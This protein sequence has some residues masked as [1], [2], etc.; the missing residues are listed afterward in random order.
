[1]KRKTSFGI[2]NFYHVFNRGVEKRK[3]F[4][5][6]KDYQRF[7]LL[8]FFCNGSVP[9]QMK[10][11]L[12]QG[13]SQGPSLGKF[14]RGKQLVDI[15][16]YCLMPNHFHLLLKERVENG[17]TNFMRKLCTGYSM[18]FNIKNNR[19]GSLFQSRFGAQHLDKDIYLKYIFAYIHLNPI[20]LAEPSWKE[21]N[22]FKNLKNVKEAEKFLEN[23]YWSSYG[24][25]IGKNN[26][27]PI[28][29]TRAFPKYFDNIKEFK[30]FINNWLNY[31]KVRPWEDLK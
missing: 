8:L 17:V 30:N 13:F 11:I 4:L 27:D 29:N 3:I 28:L 21:E 6:N 2:N 20:K 25:Y 23:Y 10:E 9:I 22:Y 26:T 31:F 19:V 14:E 24:K 1:M 5:T 7:L 12:R 15:G 18:Y 16:A